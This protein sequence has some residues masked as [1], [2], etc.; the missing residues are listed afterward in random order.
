MRDG[1]VTDDADK[2]RYYDIMLHEIE[3]LSRLISDMMQLS[4]LQSDEVKLM[5]E[6][7]D[8]SDIVLDMAESY[9]GD[10]EGKGASLAVELGQELIALADADRVE[11][12]LVIL[13][14]NAIKF[15]DDHG[16]ISLRTYRNGEGMIC[17]EVSDT[18]SGISEEDL[19]HI[20]DRFYKA[21]RSHAYE[22]TGLGLS[23]ALNIIEKMDGSIH[24]SS[25]LGVGTT[26]TV[27]L[28][29]IRKP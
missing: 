2:Q 29:L 27:E 22:G 13:I 8:V 10:I 20:F 17:I 18:G 7:L 12:V 25:K 15:S 11:Q 16:S 21:D 14:D 28:K 9:R 1:L 26:M 5:I 6:P 24:C 4:R 3:R 19:P 23:I